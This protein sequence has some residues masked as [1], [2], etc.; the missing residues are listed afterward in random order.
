MNVNVHRA[1]LCA[2]ADHARLLS[3]PSHHVAAVA[4]GAL[5]A[6]QVRMMHAG[7]FVS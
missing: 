5:P 6:S 7:L 2:E 1:P 3:D 4:V